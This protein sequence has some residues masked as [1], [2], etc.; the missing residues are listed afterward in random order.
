MHAIIWLGSERIGRPSLR[1]KRVLLGLAALLVLLLAVVLGGYLYERHRTGSVYHP[2]ARFVPEPT[3]RLPTS[4][5]ERFSR[6]FYEYQKPPPR[7]SPPPPA[8]PPPFRRLWVHNSG[9][10]LEFPPVI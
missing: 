9:A 8:L 10:L 1:S 6:P 3:P 5:P 4:R 7:F 2:H